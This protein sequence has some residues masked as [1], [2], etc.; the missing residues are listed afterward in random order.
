MGGVYGYSRIGF[1]GYVVS[2]GH[3]PSISCRGDERGETANGLR[4]P[5]TMLIS[6]ISLES[7][8]LSV[9]LHS[10]TMIKPTYVFISTCMEKITIRSKWFR[11]PLA[12]SYSLMLSPELYVDSCILGLS[13]LAYRV[14]ESSSINMLVN[15]L[16]SIDPVPYEHLQFWSMT[17]RTAVR[18]SFED[19]VGGGGCFSCMPFSGAIS[20][21][22]Q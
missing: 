2:F 10:S 18:Q 19:H 8:W 3:P 20:R 5:W 13:I 12:D 11:W 1:D 14:W 15:S 7:I 16:F 6:K 17:G 21:G 9:V 22:L 4:E